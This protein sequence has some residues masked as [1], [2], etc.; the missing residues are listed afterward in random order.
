MKCSSS[1]CLPLDPPFLLLTAWDGVACG[2]AFMI[3]GMM[4]ALQRMVTL[5][6]DAR[7]HS[8]TVV[9]VLGRTLNSPSAVLGP[10]ENSP[11]P[12]GG[13][14]RG[15]PWFATEPSGHSQ[16]SLHSS[17]LAVRVGPGEREGA[18]SPSSLGVARGCGSPNGGSHLGRYSTRTRVEY[19]PGTI[20]SPAM[21][22]V[23][24]EPEDLSAMGADDERL[25]E[26]VTLWA[27][28]YKRLRKLIQM[29]DWREPED[30]GGANAPSGGLAES[31]LT[32]STQEGKAMEMFS[33]LSRGSDLLS[34]PGA[35]TGNPTK[36]ARAFM[37]RRASLNPSPDGRGDEGRKLIVAFD[38]QFRALAKSS[39]KP[40]TMD[41]ENV[42]TGD[43]EPNGWGAKD[44]KAAGFDI[45]AVACFCENGL[46]EMIEKVTAVI[47]EKQWDGIQCTVV[48][49]WSGIDQFDLTWQYLHKLHDAE[50]RDVLEAAQDLRDMV[51]TMVMTTAGGRSWNNHGCKDFA[52]R[53]EAVFY[54]F[55]SA[56][57]LCTR[58][59]PLMAKALRVPQTNVPAQQ[60]RA[61]H[62]SATAIME[63]VINM[64][65]SA[66]MLYV[67]ENDKVFYGFDAKPEG[68][69]WGTSAATKQTDS[70]SSA[71]VPSSSSYTGPSLP[72]APAGGAVSPTLHSSHR[73][74]VRSPA[75]VEKSAEPSS[76]SL[77]VPLNPAQMTPEM[78]D[79]LL[80]MLRASEGAP[81]GTGSSSPPPQP[82]AQ[83][84][85][86]SVRLVDANQAV[87]G[88]RD[89]RLDG[90]NPPQSYRHVVSGGGN[91]AAPTAAAAIGSRAPRPQQAEAAP[92]TVHTPS[93]Q[94]RA[95]PL[96]E[97]MKAIRDTKS[98]DDN[99]RLM[100][101][102]A[103]ERERMAALQS[104]LLLDVFNEKKGFL[105]EFL[106]VNHI[107]KLGVVW[108]AD[109][110]DTSS[111]GLSWARIEQ[112]GK[113]GQHNLTL[114]S[115]KLSFMLRHDKPSIMKSGWFR[116]DTVAKE[117]QRA[118]YMKDENIHLAMRTVV[119]FSRKSRFAFMTL[120]SD[121]ADGKCQPSFISA[122]Q[123]HS[124][125]VTPERMQT[126]QGQS[127]ERP[128][129]FTP[130][131]VSYGVNMPQ[132][133]AHGT[134]LAKWGS[135]VTH[136]LEHSRDGS[137]GCP[138]DPISRASELLPGSRR[139]NTRCWLYYDLPRMVAE[140]VK[141]V[142]KPT[143]ALTVHRDTL[144]SKYLFAVV[145]HVNTSV[146]EASILWPCEQEDFIIV[147]D[148]G[149]F[150]ESLMSLRD[151][152]R[153]EMG[154]I[155]DTVATG[156]S[157]RDGA[158]GKGSGKGLVFTFKDGPI[159]AEQWHT[160]QKRARSSSRNRSS[161]A[162][163]DL[164]YECGQPGH[165]RRDCP[166]KGKGRSSS[167]GRSTSRQRGPSERKWYPRG[168]LGGVY[169][170]D[171]RPVAGSTDEAQIA[172]DLAASVAGVDPDAIL[173]QMRSTPVG[174]RYS[175]DLNKM[176][177][178][179]RIPGAP[180]PLQT[181]SG[182]AS[183]SRQRSA[184]PRPG[185]RQRS[186]SR[187]QDNVPETLDEEMSDEA[188]LR[189][190]DRSRRRELQR[191][192][193]E[194]RIEKKKEHTA[195]N[196]L[197][198]SFP[199]TAVQQRQY[200]GGAA[201]D[202]VATMFGHRVRSQN[203][204]KADRLTSV[205]GQLRS[206]GRAITDYRWANDPEGRKAR[207]TKGVPDGQEY[208]TKV[209]YRCYGCRRL[210]PK[211]IAC[212]DCAQPVPSQEAAARRQIMAQH[213]WELAPAIPLLLSWTFFCR[214]IV[215]GRKAHGAQAS[216]ETL[217]RY[218][219][220]LIWYHSLR[221]GGVA[222]ASDVA[223]SHTARAARNE[224][225]DAFILEGLDL[226]APV[227]ARDLE[228]LDA[229]G[230]ITVAAVPINTADGDVGMAN[231]CDES[232]ASESLSG[233]DYS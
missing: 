62:G 186:K 11:Y 40:D 48:I 60:Y 110:S 219:N 230:H 193:V 183:S 111:A 208:D 97:S 32:S 204:D 120:L 106:D 31:R 98:F 87:G 165:H 191:L 36:L 33:L 202:P 34:G 17:E 223:N 163:N 175:I 121:L 180:P 148:G 16:Y 63:G 179:P 39:G 58:G 84:A 114:L 15:S 141:V 200:N 155:V 128:Y 168:I 80:E 26:R 2:H 173:M 170:G 91:A 5:A 78:R 67:C 104:N 85:A 12:I 74:T 1:L 166:H 159:E 86:S 154:W 188:A 93:V 77:M 101:S 41:L 209:E 144:P 216:V 177:G 37:T 102:R 207:K 146:I 89:F 212:P 95:A 115:K 13:K 222:D 109:D 229:E 57:I 107:R 116:Y 156:G 178:K 196:E 130:G 176:Q 53:S 199:M 92:E 134:S 152:L 215:L 162:S 231:A 70:S 90:P 52:Y 35:P 192:T 125:N 54:R 18:S 94:L 227:P 226:V 198:R 64:A 105:A 4:L 145:D 59:I 46:A 66:R 29:C 182:S 171:S 214:A 56:K 139:E 190:D 158:D 9:L 197:Q 127:K 181:A 61:A 96:S 76:G 187:K 79:M 50:L 135:I 151:E 49:L 122:V 124:S 118:H 138:V 224:S 117:C 3:D 225:E 112:E 143:G 140:G 38:T 205:N 21:T 132:I 221:Q 44:L 169:T 71:G 22:I 174:K 72:S 119:R 136:G 28:W 157:T 82:A 45:D 213:G 142:L 149:G 75:P 20:P 233:A 160:V 133:F 232:S 167:K 14:Y 164:C 100:L 189:E 206:Q 129:G 69:R 55:S 113:G 150:Y 126:W 185:A 137:M 23:E 108:T 228:S 8:I 6:P 147:K 65:A 195:R 83:Q 99:D 51:H 103:S 27:A 88:V 73:E 184:T 153:K 131:E 25:T 201:G 211:S 7:R 210:Y 10:T 43:A 19:G 68:R 81:V 218:I 30:A 47:A 220:T 203:L 123:G 161:S 194:A 42:F 217:A 24:P 172:R